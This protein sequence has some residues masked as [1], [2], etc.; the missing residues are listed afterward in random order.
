[1]KFNQFGFQAL[2][3]VA[4]LLAVLAGPM[5]AFSQVEEGHYAIITVGG[6]NTYDVEIEGKAYPCYRH[7]RLTG[8]ILYQIDPQKG[9]VSAAP[10]TVEAAPY[11][12]P[13]AGQ[14]VYIV[15][16]FDLGDGAGNKVFK[17]T[18]TGVGTQDFDKGKIFLDVEADLGSFAYQGTV[19]H[20]ATEAEYKALG[21]PPARTMS[22]PDV[23]GGHSIAR[24][25]DKEK[26]I[27][28]A[29]ANSNQP[30][31]AAKPAT[32]A[33]P[34]KRPTAAPGSGFKITLDYSKADASFTPAVRTQLEEAARFLAGFIADDREVRVVVVADPGVTALASA[35]PSEW[36][37]NSDTRSVSIAGGIAF[38]P[39]SINDVN[40][41]QSSIVALTVHELLHVLGFT[42][43]AKVY[44]KY[45]KGGQFT[46]PVTVKMNNGQPVAGQGG[47]FAQGVK[48]AHGLAPRMADGGGDLLSVLDL[49]VLS[50]LGYS[51]PALKGA[52]APP[53]L[54]FTLHPGQ[55]M[56]MHYPD[57]TP[58]F[59]LQGYGGNDTLIAGD[60]SLKNGK[61]ATFL[62]A[63]AGG[64]DVFVSGP[65]DD[66]MRGDNSRAATY[67]TDGKDTFVITPDS[68]N[69]S[70]MDLDDNDVILLSPA[71]GLSDLAKYLEDDQ[72]IGAKSVPGTQ[73][74]YQGTYL[75]KLGKVELS[76]STR[77]QQKPTV[78]NFKIGEWKASN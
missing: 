74:Y 9:W 40:D 78:G 24:E 69:D 44:A 67:G 10:S 3:V 55:N 52:P 6:K 68:G 71:F 32:E 41:K 72:N 28:A 75:L 36:E 73:F 76:I 64:D 19:R 66:E 7:G 1:M 47:H 20:Y 70:I 12:M 25:S 46:G 22:K 35:A 42:E 48:D 38:N 62:M 49:A 4:V 37:E 59:L 31:N 57:G 30:A 29:A 60:V 8:G 63:G 27:A 58:A 21:W 50:D 61:K 43:S 77:N 56:V 13:T 17:A 33:E 26:A 2:F 39:K 65:G 11:A 45:S 23:D 5:T 16:D 51:I 34:A 54:G 14:P 18:V 15:M 53:V